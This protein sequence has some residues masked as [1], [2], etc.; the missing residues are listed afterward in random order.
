MNRLR[1]R[2]RSRRR[3]R[4]DYK[5][6]HIVSHHLPDDE[7]GCGIQPDNVNGRG[8]VMR[9]HKASHGSMMFASTVLVV[10]HWQLRPRA[11]FARKRQSLRLGPYGVCDVSCGRL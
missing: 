9:G 2:R 3:N 7:E 8:V 5:L 11:L 1:R 4:D 10:A 6:Q